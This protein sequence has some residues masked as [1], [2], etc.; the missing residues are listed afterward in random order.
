MLQYVYEF[1]GFEH[2]NWNNYL[3]HYNKQNII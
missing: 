2:M 3:A 1:C